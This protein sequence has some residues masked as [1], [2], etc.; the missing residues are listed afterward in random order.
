LQSSLMH[1]YPGQPMQFYSGVDTRHRATMFV[2][3]SPPCQT[4]PSS[5]EKKPTPAASGNPTSAALS[6][7]LL[8]SSQ[9]V[10]GAS[11]QRSRRRGTTCPNRRS[12][13]TGKFRYQRVPQPTPAQIEAGFLVPNSSRNSPTG[14]RTRISTECA[15]RCRIIGPAFWQ[16]AVG[17]FVSGA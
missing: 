6:R 7:N 3:T 2:A 17:F 1:F 14:M 12:S 16:V 5:G 13:R 9:A 10:S 11:T 4:L 8:Y 15:G